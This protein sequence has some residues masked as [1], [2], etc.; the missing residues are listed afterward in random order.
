MPE[1]EWCVR[2]S[3]HYLDQLDSRPYRA[4]KDRIERRV[5][6]LLR[7]PY[8]AGGAER[9]KHTLRGIRSAELLGGLRLYYRIC[10]DCRLNEDQTYRP[11]DCCLTGATD[12]KTVSILMVSAHYGDKLPSEFEFVVDD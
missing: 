5:E 12:D 4:R 11:L 3:L 7:D 1:A 2:R 6:V 10:G 9:L 8:N